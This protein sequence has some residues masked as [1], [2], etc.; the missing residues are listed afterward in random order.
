MKHADYMFKHNTILILG[1]GKEG[2]AALSYLVQEGCQSIAVADKSLDISIAKEFPEVTDWYVGDR[3][4]LFLSSYE[5]IFRSPG[6]PLRYLSNYSGTILSSTELFL[7]RHREKTIGVTGTKG[8]ST[9]VS[10]LHHI[11][12]GQG[13]GSVLGGNIGIPPLSLIDHEADVFILELSSYQLEVVTVSPRIGVLL[14]LFPDHLDH[15]GSFEQYKKAKLAIVAFQKEGDVIILPAIYREEFTELL[16]EASSKKYF[17]NEGSR[18]YVVDD[19]LF[20]RDRDQGKILLCPVSALPL[21]GKGMA[22]N[23]CA[24]LETVLAAEELMLI[25]KPDWNKVAQSLQSFIPLPHRLQEV[26]SSRGILFVNDSISTIPEATIN[27][28]EVYSDKVETLILGGYDRGIPYTVLLE[29]LPSTSVRNLIL[30]PPAGVRMKDEI[31]SRFSRSYAGITIFEAD[32]M[33]Q[34][35]QLAYQHTSQDKVCLLS[36]AAPSFGLFRNFEE[37]GE[38]FMRLVKEEAE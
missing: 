3:W 28:L 4:L 9:S 34:A 29:Y 20:V 27:A 15:H 24:V 2:K 8:K 6:V 14:N 33:A 7:K 26:C 5:V 17:A 21:K 16:P 10:L 32:T 12:Q 19:G 30:I 36:P 25:R 31:T 18:V 1:F 35:V 37:R 38:A 23:V 22:A 11:L 13:V